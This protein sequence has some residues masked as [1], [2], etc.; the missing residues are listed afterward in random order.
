MASWNRAP[1]AVYDWC[2][3]EK[4]VRTVALMEADG[5]FTANS[6]RMDELLR[7]SWL[8]IFQRH[9]SSPPPDWEEFKAKYLPFIEGRGAKMT[10]AKLDGKALKRALGAM[11]SRTSPGIDGWR[12]AELKALPQV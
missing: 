5:S 11:S 4:W 12:V 2:K 10:L 3:G 6:T 7:E 1:K 8:P 9:A